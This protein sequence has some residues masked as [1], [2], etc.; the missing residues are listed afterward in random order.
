MEESRVERMVENSIGNR[1]GGVCLM[2]L[3]GMEKT[4]ADCVLKT[5]MGNPNVQFLST[6]CTDNANPFPFFFSS[7]FSNISQVP[8]SEWTVIMI[9]RDRW[10]ASRFSSFVVGV[11][12]VVALPLPAP[13]QAPALAWVQR[14]EGP[15]RHVDFPGAITSDNAGNVYVAG[16]S[17]SE[18]QYDFVTIKYSSGVPV[19]T[20]RYDGEIHWSDQPTAIGVRSTCP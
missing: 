12:C 17:L 5:K 14:Y 8:K 6:P 9:L 1:T 4:R 2:G 18:N 16:S 10:S 11:L 19:W 20:N 3:W 7:P 15:A 13:A